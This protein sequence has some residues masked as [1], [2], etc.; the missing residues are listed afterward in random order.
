[1][2][3]TSL[4]LKG[5]SAMKRRYGRLLLG[6]AV[7]ALPLAAQGETMSGGP[8]LLEPAGARQAGMGDMFGALSGDINALHYNV[9][10]LADLAAP[11]VSTMVTSGL[12]DS[13]NAYLSAGLP[14]NWFGPGAVAASML[15]WMGAPMDVIEMDGTTSTLSSQNDLVV[16]LGYGQQ[17]GQGLS[18]GLSVKMFRSTLL[19]DYS[20]LAFGGD[21]GILQKDLIWTGLQAG[22]SLQNVGTEIKYLEVGDP[23]PTTLRIGA[24]YVLPVTAGHGLRLGMDLLLPNDG[25]PQQNLGAEY[26]WKDQLFARV[27]YRLDNGTNVLTAGAG[28]ALY[29][30]QLDYA[31]TSAI[32]GQTT[33]RLGLGY[34]FGAAAPAA[35]STP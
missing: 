8:T 7:L 13:R 1:M 19:E 30:L 12:F 9:A 6:L 22:V 4:H 31:F 16:T 35:G 24:A 34:T 27:G 25:D 26:A 20:A 14:V 17:L 28:L 21:V 5:V 10:G 29:G 3:T 15:S 2:K 18:T 33:N 11:Q 32:A 23:M